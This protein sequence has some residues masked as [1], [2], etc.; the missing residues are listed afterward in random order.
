MRPVTLFALFLALPSLGG[1]NYIDYQRIFNRIDEDVL[2]AKYTLALQRLDS[3]YST[4]D[5]IYARHCIKALQICCKAN[6]SNRAALFLAKCFRQ[7]VPMWVVRNHELMRRSLHYSTTKHIVTGYDSLHEAYKA[8]INLVLARQVDS[9]F[10]IDQR[11]TRRV[12]DGFI[13]FRY[14]IYYPQWRHNN[15]RQFETIATIMDKYG[16]PGERLVGLPSSIDDSSVSA[17][18]I[19]FYGPN[20][21]DYRAYFMLIHYYSNP[22]R[23]INDRLYRNILNGNIPVSHYAAINDFLARWGEGKYGS[24]SYYNSWQHDPDTS[25][26]SRINQ[27]RVS[28]GLNTF[29]QQERNIILNREW[30]KERSIG[31]QIILEQ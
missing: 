7:G 13:L 5:F 19:L 20:L 16:L 11:R 6:D 23:D 15:R 31:L 14:T 21:F 9:L 30:R 29:E 10:E 1:Q 18:N 25:N 26:I 28:M 17:R 27:L 2:S 8:S 12:N 3:I 4:Y 24:Y 22:R